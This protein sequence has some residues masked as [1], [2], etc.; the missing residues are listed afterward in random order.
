MDGSQSDST[1]K[2]I[3]SSDLRHYIAG[4]ENKMLQVLFETTFATPPRFNPITLCGPT[5]VGKSHLLH[6]LVERHKTW[7]SEPRTVF[8][9]GSDFA[10]GF[11]RAI[12]I[13]STAE[14]HAR[15]RNASLFVIDDLEELLGKVSAQQE[16]VHT[17]D[18]M[19]ED[20]RQMVFACRHAI[21]DW[22]WMIPTLRSRLEGG[23]VIPVLP[24]SAETRQRMLQE[25]AFEHG[26]TPDGCETDSPN[27]E[28]LQSVVSQHENLYQGLN[29]PQIRKAV[30]Q[31][32]HQFAEP[33][34]KCTDS[35]NVRASVLKGALPKIAKVVARHSHVKLSD[36]LGPSRR[37]TV[38]RARG[39]AFFLARTMLG[40]SFEEIGHYFG[41][42]DHTTVLHSWR[43]TIERLETDVRLKH[44]VNKLTGLLADNFEIQQP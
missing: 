20:E 6:G 26:L 3:G 28:A 13:D 9:T 44:E 7:S 22:N 21:L 27:C 4:P 30:L 39:V 43:K 36:L 18:A 2:F 19:R 37:Q 1:G 10:R 35:E 41:R 17:I 34:A 11:A 33:A 40:L 14:W 16:L 25:I 31:H 5:G 12:E 32:V 8:L 24:P 23:L 29:Y 42:R 15:Q 38:V